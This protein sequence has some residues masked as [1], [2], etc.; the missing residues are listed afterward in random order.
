M[1]LSGLC[2]SAPGLWGGL[3]HGEAALPEASSGAGDVTFKGEVRVA[4]RGVS[5]AP[6]TNPSPPGTSCAILEKEGRER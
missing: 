6:A 3:A 2:E 4:A 1:D 5:R